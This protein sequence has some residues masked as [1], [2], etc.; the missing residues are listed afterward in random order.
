MEKSLTSYSGIEKRQTVLCRESYSNGPFYRSPPQFSAIHH[1]QTT[2][3]RNKKHQQRK[4]RN[5]QNL[6][7][8]NKVVKFLNLKTV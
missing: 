4:Q 3:K 8:G 5:K 2:K 1:P 7:D 6:K